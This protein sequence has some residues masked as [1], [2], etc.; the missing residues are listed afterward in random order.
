MCAF[1]GCILIVIYILI[2]GHEENKKLELSYSDILFCIAVIVA[3]IGYNF[4]AKLT[5]IMVSAD[6][7]SWALVHAVEFFPLL[8]Q[9]RCKPFSD[10]VLVELLQRQCRQHL[11]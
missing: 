5:K 11:R 3:A 8:F 1:I 10:L 6:V 2:H 4:G 9:D 7:I